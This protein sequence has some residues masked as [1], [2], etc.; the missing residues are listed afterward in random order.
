MQETVGGVTYKMVEL[1]KDL[2]LR[3]HKKKDHITPALAELRC[4][5]GSYRIDFRIVLFCF[6]NLSW[7]RSIADMLIPFS[8]DHLAHRHI[9]YL[10]SLNSSLEFK[11]DQAFSVAA[12]LWNTLPLQNIWR[13]S[14]IGDLNTHLLSLAGS[15]AWNFCQVHP[16]FFEQTLL[17]FVEVEDF[18]VFLDKVKEN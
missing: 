16:Y 17:F 6:Q 15:S 12:S 3:P 4:S 11:G 13:C 9:C 1:S 2:R 14:T 7:F 5:P 8:I 18:V 10:K